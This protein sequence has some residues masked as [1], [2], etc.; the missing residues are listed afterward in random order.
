MTRWIVLTALFMILMNTIYAKNHDDGSKQGSTEYIENVEEESDGLKRMILPFGFKLDQVALRS[1]IGP[2][3]RKYCTPR[4]DGSFK[5]YRY[6]GLKFMRA[7][8]LKL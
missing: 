6:M 2:C 5:L 3:E 8:V 1:S 4:S 7:T